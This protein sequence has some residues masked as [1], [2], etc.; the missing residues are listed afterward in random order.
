MAKLLGPTN[1]KRL[2]NKDAA[3]VDGC[4][5][6]ANPYALKW[7]SLV[8]FFLF[9]WKP[10]LSTWSIED[11]PTR[12]RCFQFNR[13]TKWLPPVTSPNT[14][15]LCYIY[16]ISMP[17]IYNINI[18]PSTSHE[19]YLYSSMIALIH[20]RSLAIYTLI[21]RVRTQNPNS[22][23]PGQHGHSQFKLWHTRKPPSLRSPLIYICRP[24]RA[25]FVIS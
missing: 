11:E 15:I 21:M 12:Y 13:P 6:I 7:K 18:M 14:Y 24:P 17:H 2:K 10:E 20:N 8:F 3:H 9:F 5:P 22:A 25:Q 1:P 23:L 16:V 4:Q 19:I